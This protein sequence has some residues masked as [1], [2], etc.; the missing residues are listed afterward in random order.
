MKNADSSKALISKSN[1]D[2]EGKA[3]EG[4]KPSEEIGD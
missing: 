1:L 2:P 3:G 4:T